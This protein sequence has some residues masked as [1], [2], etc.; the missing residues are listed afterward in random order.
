MKLFSA[1]AVATLLAMG[2]L[3]AQAEGSCTFIMENMFAG[4][5]QVCEMP[6]DAARCEALGQEDDNRDAVHAAAACP[7]DDIVGICD[8]GDVQQVYYE[9]DT[10]GLEIGCGFQGGD[11]QDG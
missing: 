5:F 10:M 9:G 6:A 3:G 7:T 8:M 1:L 2:P 11:W 4:P